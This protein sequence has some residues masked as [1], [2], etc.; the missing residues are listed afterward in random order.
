[1][2]LCDCLFGISWDAD[3]LQWIWMDFNAIQQDEA[4]KIAKLPYNWLNYG[5][6]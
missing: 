1:M 6:W 3:G 2:R 5:L 4:P